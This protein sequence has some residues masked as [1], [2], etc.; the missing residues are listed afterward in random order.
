MFR[1]QLGRFASETFIP[2]PCFAYQTKSPALAK[3]DR[4]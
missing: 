1:S 3:V 2:L 4:Q